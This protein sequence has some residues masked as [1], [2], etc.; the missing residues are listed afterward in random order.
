MATDLTKL[1]LLPGIPIFPTQK[2]STPSAPGTNIFGSASDANPSLTAQASALT[3]YNQPKAPA[4][5]ASAPP[6][7]PAPPAPSQPQ[8]GYDFSK[9]ALTPQANVGGTAPG[10]ASTA[11]QQMADRVQ[12]QAYANPNTVQ[13][14][15]QMGETSQNPFIAPTPTYWQADYQTPNG[16][17]QPPP[18]PSG[19]AQGSSAAYIQALNNQAKNFKPETYID[20][21]GNYQVTNAG[22]NAPT[23]DKF[24]SQEEYQAANEAFNQALL[25]Q[26]YQRVNS[27]AQMFAMQEQSSKMAWD[28]VRA[29]N[30]AADAAQ[31]QAANEASSQRLALT[32]TLAARGLNP[33]TDSWAQSK[34]D[35]FDRLE[36]DKESAIA[37]QAA[38]T[39]EEANSDTY[40]EQQK[41]L[42]A[43]I[44]DL[45][46]A[47]A[48]IATSQ[49]R[50]TKSTVDLGSLEEKKRANDIR[51]QLGNSK[52]ELDEAR[53]GLD[54]GKA[55]GE[56]NGKE[57]VQSR[58][59]SVQE[60]LV[61]PKIQQMLASAGLSKAKT[62]RLTQLTPYEVQEKIAQINKLRAKAT[63]GNGALA[64]GD[65]AQVNQLASELFGEDF[66]SKQNQATARQLLGIPEDKRPSVIQTIK[67]N[68]KAS[69]R[70]PSPSAI[71]DIF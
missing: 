40:M 42:D 18:P 71:S 6:A 32:N 35:E 52:S 12:A 31:R 65:I 24:Q 44:K 48:S 68:I 50:E 11:F 69:P 51:L 28:K 60:K 10:M 47:M 53:L 55:I 39:Y 64:T 20:Q 33:K 61:D 15:A 27:P 43:R 66:S 67:S 8:G 16:G 37:A 56:V 70:Q 54:T 22:Y 38:M 21:N 63:A 23:P 36:R 2:M 17:Y 7:P 5:Q 30:M 62:D 9:D 29:K 41:V 26:E 19:S 25:Q 49:Q 46:A 45:N 3:K 59:T 1:E 4:P 13:Q 57:T 14:G 58:G 34:L